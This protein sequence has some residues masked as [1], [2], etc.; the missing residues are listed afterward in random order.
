MVSLNKKDCRLI[1]TKGNYIKKPTQ[2]NG[3]QFS[4]AKEIYDNWPTWKKE[5]YEKSCLCN[6]DEMAFNIK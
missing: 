6:R 4:Y 2:N 1:T 3:W 5:V